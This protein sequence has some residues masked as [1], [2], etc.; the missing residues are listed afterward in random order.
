MHG[1]AI[2]L[3]F[4][5]IGGVRRTQSDDHCVQSLGFVIARFAVS[6]RGDRLRSIDQVFCV[7][8]GGRRSAR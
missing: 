8:P 7:D 4:E 6:L 1:L 2:L 3:S 5:V